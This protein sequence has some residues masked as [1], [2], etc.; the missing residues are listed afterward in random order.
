M[1]KKNPFSYPKS[2]NRKALDE[3]ELSIHLTQIN[4][5]DNHKYREIT[6]DIEVAVEVEFMENI[7]QSFDNLYFWTYNITIVN[8]GKYAITLLHRH[9]YII[10]ANGEKQEV[11]GEGVI[12]KK[13]RIEAGASFSYSSGVHLFTNFGIMRGEYLMKREDNQFIQVAI[14]QFSLSESSSNDIVN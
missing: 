6:N 3:D 7:R 14:P 11:D 8:K 4:V 10:D 9:W 13:P 2:S 12:G 1:S 5:N